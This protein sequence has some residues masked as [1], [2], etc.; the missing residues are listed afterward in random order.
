MWK[1][2]SDIIQSYGRS[3]RSKD[4]YAK[5]YILDGSFSNILKYNS[6]LIP[7]WFLDAITYVD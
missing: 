6:T 2:V 3:I 1:T 4:D 7:Q 5:T